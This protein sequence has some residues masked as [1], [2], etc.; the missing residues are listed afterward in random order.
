MKI[1]FVV[2]VAVARCF[3]Q[4]SG[5]SIRANP[6]PAPQEM[7]WGDFNPRPMDNRLHVSLN[8]PNHI[9]EE[10]IER[11]K[12]SVQSLKWVPATWEEPI[13]S[14]PLTPPTENYPRERS[15]KIRESL[16]VNAAITTIKINVLNF[17]ADLQMGVNETHEL[18]AGANSTEILITAETTWGALHAL[19]TLR[20]I[21]FYDRE[22]CQFYLELDLF[23]RDWPL[24]THRGVLIDSG[25][26][27][28]SI[29]SILDQIDL[30]SISKMNVLHW[31]LVDTQSWP[32]QLSTFPEMTEVASTQNQI[33]SKLDVSFIVTYAK[34][35]G[36]R[37][38]PE[39]DMP[40]HS[41]AGYLALNES[42]LACAN[43]WWS[44]DVYSKHTAVEPPPGQL[45]ILKNETYDVVSNIYNELSEIFEDHV[46]HVG[47]DEL[48]ENC[49][50]SSSITQEWFLVNTSRTFSDLYQYWVDKA[51]PIFQSVADR[52]LMMW[53]DIVTDGAHNVPKEV[54]LQTWAAN[55][56]NVKKLTSK[57]HDVVISTYNYIYLD[58]GY[59]GWV[60]NDPRYVQVPPNDEFNSGLG[61]SW[62]APYKTW[63]RIY[64]FEL[65]ANLTTEE[66]SHVLGAEAAIWGEQVDSIVLVLKTWPRTAALAENLW[67]GNRNEEGYL[68]TNLMTLRILNFRE[69]LVAL[70][71][72]VSP[73]VPRF[74]LLNPHACDLYR[75]QTVL[76]AYS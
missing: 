70:G 18:I 43:T 57:G 68:R 11:F 64:D 10:A 62:C 34:H 26:N 37:V 45:E 28:L 17:T 56:A 24:Y 76:D 30:L 69:F 21:I 27:F 41:R 20:Q 19:N 12:A 44:N 55:N 13:P 4:V 32:I 71:Y 52:R 50:N 2:A 29:S 9:I 7:I 25:R 51:V 63:Q 48:Q 35:R 60:T 22:S 72:S 67:S 8:E 58:C 16:K 6:L 33:Y 36:V 23:I 38:I 14:Y 74:C 39:L 46:F 54:I 65:T 66:R 61:G 31:H 5:L 73:L 42:I 53:E 49:Y 47:G 15:E 1:S 40:G 59:G 3:T 75:N